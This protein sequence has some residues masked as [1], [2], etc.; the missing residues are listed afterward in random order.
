MLVGR[1]YFRL[2]AI[3]VLAKGMRNLGLRMDGGSHEVKPS[4]GREERKKRITL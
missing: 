2:D 4:A 3:I 1:L